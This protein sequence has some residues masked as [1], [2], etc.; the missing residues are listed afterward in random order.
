MI[1]WK[2]VYH[3]DFIPI[4]LQNNRI[5]TESHLSKKINKLKPSFLKDTRKKNLNHIPEYLARCFLLYY[6][7][8][9]F[10]SFCIL[11]NLIYINFISQ[12]LSDYYMYEGTPSPEIWSSLFNSLLL[13][14]F[15]LLKFVSIFFFF[16]IKN[17][18]EVVI[19][20]TWNVFGKKRRFVLLLI[21]FDFRMYLFS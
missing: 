21:Q 4:Q 17:R 18:T 7:L 11:L 2:A 3:L 5:E 12:V 19:I 15:L 9:I 16:I 14:L 1:F 20:I 6:T 8:T 13:F 10:F